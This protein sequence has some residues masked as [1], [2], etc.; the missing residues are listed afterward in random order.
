MRL[1]GV[2]LLVPLA[3]ILAVYWM[4]WWIYRDAQAN[5]RAGTP[6]MLQFGRFRIETPI[7]W[8][9]GCWLV[10]YILIPLYMSARK[11]QF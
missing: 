5:V 11:R 1:M 2:L 8:F 9:F 7:A 10:P 3:L 6:V 4:M